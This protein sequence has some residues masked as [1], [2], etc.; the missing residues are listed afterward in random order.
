MST[1]TTILI[2]LL[3]TVIG[4]ALTKMTENYFDK[5]KEIKLFIASIDDV[6]R[7][8]WGGKKLLQ[9]L[10]ALD[11]E[12]TDNLNEDNEGT[13][14]QWAPVFME[15]PDCWKLLAIRSCEVVGYW[16]FFPLKKDF[17]EKM[18]SGVANDSEITTETVASFNAP[19]YYDIYICIICIK[20]IYRRTGYTMLY[21]SLVAK[22]NEL[23]DAGYIINEVCANAF[24]DIG[25]VMSKNIGLKRLRN[26]NNFGVIYC[27]T[28]KE[29]CMSKAAR[30][31]LKFPN[32]IGS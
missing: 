18:K 1:V 17:F 8:G 3:G 13:T 20:E 21:D 23:T 15:N 11:Y 9:H 32:T 27:G 7:W 6:V 26:H 29:V 14:N 28:Y 5:K 2:G 4:V 19:G 31:K 24:T 16:S 25:E 22:L 12:T 10:I 30:N